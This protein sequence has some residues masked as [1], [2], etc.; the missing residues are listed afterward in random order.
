MFVNTRRLV[1]KVAMHLGERLG[2]DGDRVP[3]HHARN[4]GADGRSKGG[5]LARADRAVDV[6]RDL[7]LR[8]PKESVEDFPNRFALFIIE[9]ADDGRGLQIDKIKSKILKNGLATENELEQMSVQQIQ[10]FIFSSLPGTTGGTF[11][12]AINGGRNYSHE[13]LIEGLPLG[14]NLQ[15]GSNNEMSPPTEA[16]EDWERLRGCAGLSASSH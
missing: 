1:E 8:T 10:Q 12:G 9:I 13:I 2:A 16:V 4:A 3:D 15:G 7:L 11:E 14:R 5:K 6:L